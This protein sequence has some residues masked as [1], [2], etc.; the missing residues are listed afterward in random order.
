M[1]NLVCICLK[2]PKT[3]RE[4]SSSKMSF[5]RTRYP[6][7]I[8]L[9]CRKMISGAARSFKAPLCVTATALSSYYQRNKMRH[10][11]IFLFSSLLALSH[12]LLSRN[13]N[14]PPSTEKVLSTL[15]KSLVTSIP[16]D[17]QHHAVTEYLADSRI[18]EIEKIAR[19]AD[20]DRRVS[21]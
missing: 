1:V 15:R 12:P 18:R 16:T 14:K 2:Y 17:K 21:I 8:R 6:E 4:P 7:P 10:I 13:P 20:L 5:N 11:L 3:N 19:Q 9:T